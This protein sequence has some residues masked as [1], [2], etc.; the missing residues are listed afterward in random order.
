MRAYRTITDT[1]TK[2]ID[3]ILLAPRPWTIS[4]SPYIGTVHGAIG[5]ITQIVL[6]DPSYAPQ[7]ELE[8]SDLLELQS[9][10]GN[11]P[12]KLGKHPASPSADTLV[13]FCHG[14]SGFAISLLELKRFYKNPVF[15]RSLE[16]SLLRAQEC[17]W[18]KG[19]LTKDPCLC[20]GIAGS[21]LAFTSNDPT[22]KAR[23]A[24][25]CSFLKRNNVQEG[26][27]RSI[28]TESDSPLSLF[29]GEAGRAWVWA[30]AN[31]GLEAK[32][33]GYNDL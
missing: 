31:Q 9:A 18:K 33:L 32:C 28:Y 16:S 4:G 30:V 10:S 5:I 3:R 15:L 19:L 25:F 8:L 27:R 13:Q 26:F 11:F 22:S 29:T 1:A 6:T 7:L 17:I 20:H 23:F 14:A 24:H 21:A 12:S 2:I